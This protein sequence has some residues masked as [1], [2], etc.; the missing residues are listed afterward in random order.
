VLRIL[1]AG[2]DLLIVTKML[3][4][5]SNGSRTRKEKLLVFRLFIE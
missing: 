2:T 3:E 1:E 4:G 5:L